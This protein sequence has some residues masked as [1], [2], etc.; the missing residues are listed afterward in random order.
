MS[1]K[2]AITKCCGIVYGVLFS[3]MIGMPGIARTPITMWIGSQP[4]GIKAWM[5]SFVQ[6]FNDSHPTIE[7]NIEI[8]PSMSGSRDK[9]I[10]AMASNTAPDI[11]YEN[12]NLIPK[13]ASNGAALPLDKYINNWLDKKDIIPDML[14][15][16]QYNGHYY[17]IPH[18]FA[19]NGDI[20]NLD[21]MANNGAAE[22]KTWNEMLAIARKLRKMADGNTIDTYGYAKDIRTGVIASLDLELALNQLGT[23]MI[24]YGETRVQLNTD[25]GRKGIKY[26]MDTKEAGMGSYVS[27]ITDYTSLM[28]SGKVAIIHYYG[29]VSFS[30]MVATASNVKIGFRRYVGP[31]IGKDMIHISTNHIFIVATSKYPDEAWQVLEA[32]TSSDNLKNYVQVHGSVF[33]ARISLLSDFI[34]HANEANK[35]MISTVI[36]PMTSLGP[37]HKDFVDFREPAGQ[38]I[39]KAIIGEMAS[40][41]ALEE[42]EQYINKYLEDKGT[43]VK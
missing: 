17:A 32:F 41:T 42:A 19:P 28:T 3:M 34:R 12:G 27:V 6:A 9:L 39:R 35:E 8:H 24:R 31:E 36:P 33:P 43:S 21:M 23:T 38:I 16:A 13:W 1:N 4:A 10:I 29:G 25:V 40:N 37:L 22:P 2:I 11:F 7:L 15:F 30:Q 5:P 26:L 20:Y 18:I 14:G